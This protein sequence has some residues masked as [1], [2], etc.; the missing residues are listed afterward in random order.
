[1]EK[2]PPTELIPLRADQSAGHGFDVVLRGY[3]RQQVRQYRDRV[4]VDLAVAIADRDA[5]MS[6]VGALE[7]QLQNVRAELEATSKRA[8]ET[9]K[10]TYTGLGERVLQLLR[11]AEEEAVDIRSKA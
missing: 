6:R 8:A 3:D 10:P 11:L 9:S 2:E 4:E 1:M 7:Q 5:A